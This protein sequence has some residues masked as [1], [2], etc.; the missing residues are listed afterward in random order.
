MSPRSPAPT[1]HHREPRP[2]LARAPFSL[3]AR[4][5]HRRHQVTPA[6]TTDTSAS[7]LQILV[8]DRDSVDRFTMIE[9]FKTWQISA[10]SSDR[11]DNLKRQIAS[12]GYNFV[13]LDLSI[14]QNES[15]ALLHDIRC[16][17][18]IPVIVTAP[19]HI[20]ENSRAAALELG[21]DDCITKPFGSRELMA[22]IRA[23]LRRGSEHLYDNTF[24]NARRAQPRR[25]YFGGWQLDRR[26]RQ[27]T[28][29]DGTH[30]PLT[31]SEYALLAAF[32]DTPMVTLS[33]E[34]LLQATRVNEDLCDRSIDI[35]IL[36][37]RRKL[38]LEPGM[39]D[40]IRTVRG[41]GYLFMLPVENM[42]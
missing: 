41:A 30:V 23:I 1:R 29:V 11:L 4:T 42:G 38:R 7:S 6:S 14:G 8:V 2:S 12:D 27:L 17:F 24:G 5:A 36:R 18:D 9:Y 28:T 13:I 40:I 31:K 16:Q 22:R 33:R 26:T 21:A 37:L 10:V 34:Q 20:G 25:C 35:Q 39:D 32:I 19:S 3:E 15:L